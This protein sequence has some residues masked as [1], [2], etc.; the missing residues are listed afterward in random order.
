MSDPAIARP[1]D[2]DRHFWLA[3][4]MARTKG[5]RFS[6]AMRLGQLTPQ[7]FTNL[8]NTCRGCAMS[9]R[10]M[11]WMARSGATDEPIPEFCEIAEAL[12]QLCPGRRR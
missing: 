11:G 10:C 1:G 9:D 6:D 3:Q 5:V 7:S 2:L 4:G 12:E 8:V